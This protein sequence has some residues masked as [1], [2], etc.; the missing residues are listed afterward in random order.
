[1]EGKQGRDG[2]Y[3]R[4]MNQPKCKGRKRLKDLI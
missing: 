1:M 4:C 3:L 2:V